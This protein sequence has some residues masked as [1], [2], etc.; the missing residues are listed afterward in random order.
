MKTYI[1]GNHEIPEIRDEIQKVAGYLWSKGWAESNAGNISYNVTHLL[2]DFIGSLDF[3]P[4]I[5]LKTPL[6]ALNE[7][8]IILTG[9]GTRMRDV[10]VDSYKNSC[11]VQIT[12]N[13]RSWR[14]VQKPELDKQVLPTSELP[15]HLAIHN[16]LVEENRKEKVIVHTHPDNLIALTHIRE[17]CNQERINNML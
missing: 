11:V 4:P 14:Q 3:N 9:T 2:S 13:G 7:N 6:P 10:S 12:N 5:D 17:F 15:S 16:M 8:I 1:A